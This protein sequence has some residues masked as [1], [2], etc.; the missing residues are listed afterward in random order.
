LHAGAPE[1]EVADLMPA[2]WFDV[3]VA[4]ALATD[5]IGAA[6]TP[7][8][9]RIP[10]G[11]LQDREEWRAGRM[12]FDPGKVACPTLV[13]RGEWDVASTVAYVR[14][15]FDRL[16]NVPARRIVEIGRGTH[17]II[18][19]K[20]RAQLF[21]EVQLFLDESLPDPGFVRSG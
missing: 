2:E 20:A 8:F 10:A 5:A 1:G 15:I 13:L 16:T 18:V 3:W 12:L 17:M 9:V 6:Q 7:P 4:T 21:R 14:A 11:G 19:E